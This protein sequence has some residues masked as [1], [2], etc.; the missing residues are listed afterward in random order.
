[1]VA[2]GALAGCTASR[3]M[4]TTSVSYPAKS[5]GDVRLFLSDKPTVPYTEIGRVS[6][7]KYGMISLVP[8]SGEKVNAL[9]REEAAKMGGDAVIN[10]TEDFASVSGVVV[11]FT[12]SD[13]GSR[14]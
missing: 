8:A 13:S 9:L 3:A 1:M 6:V 4:R 10:I 5:P 14:R 2:C 12:S 11:V 7:D